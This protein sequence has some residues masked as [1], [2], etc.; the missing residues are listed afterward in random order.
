[1]FVSLFMP[2]CVLHANLKFSF[3][4]YN[5]FDKTLTLICVYLDLVDEL[6]VHKHLA[7]H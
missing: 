7:T 3:L 4:I 6:S 5:I 1:M 2:L